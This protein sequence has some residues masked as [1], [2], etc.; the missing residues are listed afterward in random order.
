MSNTAEKLLAHTKARTTK[1]HLVGVVEPDAKNPGRFTVDF[2]LKAG[3]YETE[4]AVIE[5]LAIVQENAAP[6]AACCDACAKRLNRVSQ[7]LSI[8]TAA[9]GVALI[10]QEPVH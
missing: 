9:P 1:R 2:A 3:V 10:T 5:L 4:I 6:G 7:A 8:L